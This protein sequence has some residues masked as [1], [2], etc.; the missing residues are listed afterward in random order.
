MLIFDTSG[1]VWD[2]A[3]AEAQL[4]EPPKTAKPMN[5][6]NTMR[7]VI[8]PRSPVV[9]VRLLR[10]AV[11]SDSHFGKC[12]ATSVTAREREWR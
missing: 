10:R 7:A 8:I 3:I 6:H 9:I 1:A 4:M 2:F 12:G 11:H 5:A